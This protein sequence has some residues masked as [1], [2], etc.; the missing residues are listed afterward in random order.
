M[1]E[2]GSQRRDTLEESGYEF[3][4]YLTEAE[5]EALLRGRVTGEL[6]VWYSNDGYAGYVIELPQSS[7]GVCGFE[8]AH[9]ATE[10]DLENF[11]YSI[12]A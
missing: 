3:I 10:D 2:R 9:E 5:D 4:N 11:N 6:S 8:F 7:G 12:P 1:K